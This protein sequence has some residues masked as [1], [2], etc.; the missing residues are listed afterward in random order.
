MGICI[1]AKGAPFSMD[2]GS[3]SFLRMRTAIAKYVGV[4][5]NG[6]PYELP[7]LSDRN[8]WKTFIGNL[9]RAIA[10]GKISHHTAQFLVASDCSARFMPASCKAILEDIKDMPEQDDRYGYVWSR[11]AS[12]GDFRMLLDYCAQ[13][14][15]MLRWS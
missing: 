12:I 15:R 11:H 7:Y 1:S 9:N 14:R 4:W 13:N 6:C 5:E 10:E 8:T 2:M 3:G